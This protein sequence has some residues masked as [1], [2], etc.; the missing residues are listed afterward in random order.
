MRFGERDRH[1]NDAYATAIYSGTHDTQSRVA[2]ESAASSLMQLAVGASPSPA[3]QAREAAT[4]SSSLVQLSESARAA[5]SV[6]AL[7]KRHAT[8]WSDDDGDAAHAFVQL[9]SGMNLRRKSYVLCGFLSPLGKVMTPLNNRLLAFL[10]RQT[11]TALPRLR[12]VWTP[13]VDRGMRAYLL[14]GEGTARRDK[15]HL[16]DHATD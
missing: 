16:A 6:R 5:D 10:V 9:T 14:G 13:L 1:L 11:P 2:H 15:A 3:R 7:R 8:H 4:A 12:F